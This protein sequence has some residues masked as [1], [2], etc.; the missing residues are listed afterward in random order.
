MPMD[1]VMR[2]SSL[3]QFAV[4]RGEE[5]EDL[6]IQYLQYLTLNDFLLSFSFDLIS[7]FLMQQLG[8]P[9]EVWAWFPWKFVWELVM[10]SLLKGLSSR[11]FAELVRCHKKS[12]YAC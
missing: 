12:G 9:G 7:F 11:V 8:F 5:F 10:S 4:Y 3:L 6:P 1:S 2:R